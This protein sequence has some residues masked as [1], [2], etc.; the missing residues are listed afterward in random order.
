MASTT[1]SVSFMLDAR[2]ALYDTRAAVRVN[3]T[4]D[5]W[6]FRVDSARV[7]LIILFVPLIVVGL[8]GN[9]LVCAAI[10]LER[11]LHN[12]TNYFLFSLAVADWFVCA[13]VMPTAM[14]LELRGG[15]WWPQHEVGTCMAYVYADVFLCTASIV[16]M[17]VISLD[18]YL[19]IS[20][21]LEIRNRSIQIVIAKIA[22]VWLATVIISCPLLVLGMHNAS[23]VLV[24]T[25][26]NRICAIHNAYYKIYGSTLAFLIPLIIMIVSYVRT[27][28][29][30]REQAL[31]LSKGS[32]KRG[33]SSEYFRYRK[34]C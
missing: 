33:S 23:N 19:G 24:I 13:L 27:T 26:Y 2:T 10:Y 29:L 5:D 7:W 16:H 18:R 15:E 8:V 20:R 12:V 6:P 17:C 34:T 32:D 25:K 22:G 9:A 11:T 14:L 21:P 28:S 4:V 3:G 31:A 30:L 1:V